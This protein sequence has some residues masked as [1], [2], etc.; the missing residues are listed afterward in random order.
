MIVFRCSH[1]LRKVV[2]FRILKRA[3]ATTEAVSSGMNGFL[4][5]AVV[6]ISHSLVTVHH[7]T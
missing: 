2:S 3:T 6:V 4:T 5:V 7:V 1:A